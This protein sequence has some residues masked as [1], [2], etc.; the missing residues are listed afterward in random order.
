M[1]DPIIIPKTP[2]PKH[3]QIGVRM[4][5]DLYD[6]INRVAEAEDVS[7]SVVAVT[8]LQAALKEYQKQ[9]NERSQNG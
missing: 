8:F 9:V 7:V 1:S 6:A 2:K 5:I 4:D 3:K